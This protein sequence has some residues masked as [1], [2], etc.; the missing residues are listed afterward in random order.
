MILLVQ[1][2]VLTPK[3]MVL[4]PPNNSADPISGTSE[5]PS[6]PIK[7]EKDSEKPQC[8]PGITRTKIVYKSVEID[9]KM[10]LG[11]IETVTFEC[12]GLMLDARIDTGA[13]TSSLSST[14]MRLFERDGK[15]WVSF[16]VNGN[17][18]NKHNKKNKKKHVFERRI[19][20]NIMIKRHDEEPQLRPVVKLKIR[21]GKIEQVAEFT[22][23]DRTKFDFP[24]LIGRNILTDIAIVDA[25][26]EYLAS[27]KT[28]INGE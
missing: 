28:M 15:P 20:R 25:S 14:N 26:H 24:V 1:I 13:I 4:P 23:T 21:I 2:I 10:V 17:K 5:Q 16:R 9:H 3:I 7:P 22:L 18:H 12:L 6:L 11:A 27:K 19:V 8:H